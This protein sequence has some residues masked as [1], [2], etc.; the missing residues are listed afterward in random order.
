[1]RLNAKVDG[2]TG[3]PKICVELSWNGGTTWTAA[4]S[5]GT[6]ATSEGSYI[7]G[8]VTDTWGRTWSDTEFS[9]ANFRVRPMSPAIHRATS[10]STGSPCTSGISSGR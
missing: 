6:L 7:L 4:K 10:R 2:N 5:T 1:V 9:N 8:G 3:A